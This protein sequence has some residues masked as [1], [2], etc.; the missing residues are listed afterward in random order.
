[1]RWCSERVF[2]RLRSGATH[3]PRRTHCA[4]GRFA[5]LH[6][7]PAQLMDVPAQQIRGRWRPWPHRL[8][9]ALA[10]DHLRRL[11]HEQSQQGARDRK[12]RHRTI[13]A[14]AFKG[15]QIQ[16]Q[17]SHAEYPLPMRFAVRKRAAA[18]LQFGE[19]EGFDQ[20]VVDSGTK[21]FDFVFECALGG[22]H[23]HRS[24]EAKSLAH[25]GHQPD[26]V[27]PGHHPVD[28]DH[29]VVVPAQQVQGQH[30]VRGR[31]Q[32]V[33]AGFEKIVHIRHQPGMV[34]DDQDTEGRLRFLDHRV[35]PPASVWHSAPR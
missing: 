14:S 22:H 10:T 2:K 30:P 29:V 24:L 18:Q 34:L 26:A 11:L 6:E 19:F 9:Q 4:A 5:A 13:A 28:H 3:S 20:I 1:M 31:V 7:L 25:P 15:V 17:I 8:D 12:Q 27:E 35:S 23:D 16:S 33:S 21:A 32:P